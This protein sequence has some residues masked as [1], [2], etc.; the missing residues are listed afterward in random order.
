MGL[1]AAQLRVRRIYSPYS[2]SCYSSPNRTTC[3][4][5]SKIT[6]INLSSL[7]K[8]DTAE[9]EVRGWPECSRLVPPLSPVCPW[10]CPPLPSP[11]S[12][13]SSSL[14]FPTPHASLT[15]VSQAQKAAHGGQHTN[16]LYGAGD[17]CLSRVPRITHW[18]AAG[19]LVSLLLTFQQTENQQSSPRAGPE[20]FF[21]AC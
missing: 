4:C 10:A 12:D 9:D 5:T 2:V 3:S 19:V 13:L 14:L 18:E 16:A 7:Y 1:H 17:F 8:A 20:P 6:D 21:P 11:H 15:W